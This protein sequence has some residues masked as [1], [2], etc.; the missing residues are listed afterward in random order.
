MNSSAGLCQRPSTFSLLF[1]AFT[2]FSQG[3]G[4]P[5]QKSHQALG[6][7]AEKSVNDTHMHHSEAHLFCTSRLQGMVGNKTDYKQKPMV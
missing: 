7:A 4:L 1:P 2:T 6:Q 3:D 5:F